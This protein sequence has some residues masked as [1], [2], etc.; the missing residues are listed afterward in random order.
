[1]K[2][3][4]DCIKEVKVKKE[5][6]T[7]VFFIGT[8]GKN[9]V[10]AQ[11]RTLASGAE[12]K[13]ASFNMSLYDQNSNME[14]CLK[15]AGKTHDAVWHRDKI[16]CIWV[17]AYKEDAD[18]LETLKPGMQVAGGGILR[19]IKN[20]PDK[21]MIMASVIFRYTEEPKLKP[22]G[23]YE[24]VG[25]DYI[26]PV[27]AKD[28]DVPVVFAGVRGKYCDIRVLSGVQMAHTQLS[29]R[30]QSENIEEFKKALGCDTVAYQ[31]ENSS[32]IGINSAVW[33]KDADYLVK[34]G[35]YYQAL[36]CGSLG[37]HSYNGK[38]SLELSVA[39]MARTFAPE[40]SATQTEEA[41]EEASQTPVTET[42]TSSPEQ[43]SQDF[44]DEFL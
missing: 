40:G 24:R 29:F 25:F 37:C 32:T 38:N 43:T 17:N 21:V 8:I 23:R 18:Y 12:I 36:G 7:P 30:D 1:M 19:A 27:R 10:K 34:K 39:S 35:Q 31:S 41:P 4:Q 5:G 9:G 42:Q 13:E 11:M 2:Y 44:M 22:T 33:R 16:D 14:Y 26:R 6:D 3:F 28:G 20:D 15:Q